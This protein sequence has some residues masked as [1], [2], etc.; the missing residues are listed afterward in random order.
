M[1]GRNQAA[2]WLAWLAV[3]LSLRATYGPEDWFGSGSLG[4]WLTPFE[5][6]YLNF[7]ESDDA[8]NESDGTDDD[9]DTLFSASKYLW[10]ARSIPGLSG[11]RKTARNANTWRERRQKSTKARSAISKLRASCYKNIFDTP[12]N[13]GPIDTSK[14]KD[15]TKTNHFETPILLV[16]LVNLVLLCGAQG[17]LIA[18]GGDDSKGAKNQVPLES[19]ATQRHRRLHELGFASGKHMNKA[20]RGGN[21]GNFRALATTRARRCSRE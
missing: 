14:G 1:I 5:A 21:N 11:K 16:V 17:G 13:E 20:T 4:R 19:K 9:D 2:W 18:R 12:S 8:S 10:A 3:T 7:P 6:D 15:Q